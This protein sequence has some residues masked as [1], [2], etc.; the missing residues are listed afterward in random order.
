[1]GA[2]DSRAA[3]GHYSVAASADKASRIAASR[4]DALADAR[5]F[6]MIG[7]L[8]EDGAR[9]PF[10]SFEQAFERAAAS[11]AGT[12][13]VR[14]GLWDPAIGETFGSGGLGLSGVGEAG[15][16]S[17]IGIGLGS[18]GT[19]GHG[20]GVD[21]IGLGGG[22]P[23]LPDWEH[24]WTW[25]DGYRPRR[26]SIRVPSS[27]PRARLGAVTLRAPGAESQKDRARAE[28]DLAGYRD[29]V[30]RIAAQSI[31]RARLCYETFVRTG[32]TA[33]DGSVTTN[34]LIGRDGQVLS[35][36][37]AGATLGDASMTS[38]VARA[39]QSSLFP[40]PPTGNTA[41]AVIPVLFDWVVR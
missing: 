19:L 24:G 2:A 10:V 25:Y 6:G 21:G 35:S 15:G 33:R 14:G 36:A 20:G 28:N 9:S 12:L 40:I 22:G 11:G 37:T 38:C 17:G 34:L 26:L 39:F 1:M 41:V 3:H 8:A 7:L 29:S 23:A 4:Q 30:R 32:A 16:G 13:G 27:G 5:A 18:I 31:G